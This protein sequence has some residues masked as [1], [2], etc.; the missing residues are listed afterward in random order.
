M[1]EFGTI[2]YYEGLLRDNGKSHVTLKLAHQLASFAVTENA[3]GNEQQENE[4]FRNLDIAYKKITEPV[5]VVAEEQVEP[6]KAA[7]LRQKCNDIYE[8]SKG[9]FYSIPAYYKP[10]VPDDIADEVDEWY[11]IGMP[12]S[13]WIL[14]FSDI[15]KNADF[16]YSEVLPKVLLSIRKKSAEQYYK[17][18]GYHRINGYAELE[19]DQKSLFSYTFDRHFKTWGTEKQKEYNPY[20]LKEIKWD[21]AENC[22]KV[23]YTNG[24]WWHYDTDGTW[25]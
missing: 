25:Y 14:R 2:E 23:Y 22:L 9:G 13:L 8:N 11:T 12:E 16:N 24:D 5:E 17:E 18:E 3:N 6:S 1:A 15:P 4:W 19:E 10:I 7:S 20:N 21:A